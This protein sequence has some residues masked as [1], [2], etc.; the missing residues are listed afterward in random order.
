MNEAAKR[1]LAAEMIQRRWRA[2]KASGTV[3]VAEND[4]TVPDGSADGA[5]LSEP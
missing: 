5:Q 4:T 1:T 3:T 2:K